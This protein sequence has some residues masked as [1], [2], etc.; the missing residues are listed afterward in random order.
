[1]VY[2]PYHRGRKKS[3]EFIGPSKAAI[4]KSPKE[5]WLKVVTPYN[6]NFVDE[7]KSTV[8]P[9]HR[10]WNPEEKYW[11]VNELYLEDLIIIL[12][13]HYDEVSTDLL[14]SE[15]VNNPFGIVFDL[16]SPQDLDKIYKALA[17]AVH[18]DRGGS[19]KSMKLLNEAYQRKK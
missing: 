3:A 6:E 19:E 5:G 7:L 17:F 18:P 8:Q 16:I 1:M 11:L 10:Q 2:K 15:E 13:R 4:L 12:K 9:P 14:E